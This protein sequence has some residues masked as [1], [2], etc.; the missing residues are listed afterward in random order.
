VDLPTGQSASSVGELVRS[1]C[2]MIRLTAARTRSEG[3]R[4]RKTGCGV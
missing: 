2:R 1:I 4:R 3:I